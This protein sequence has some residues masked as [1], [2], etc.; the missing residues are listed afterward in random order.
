MNRYIEPI[1]GVS[2]AECVF[3]SEVD[4]CLQ[5]VAF[6]SRCQ[7]R[8]AVWQFADRDTGVRVNF[9]PSKPRPVRPVR[10]PFKPAALAAISK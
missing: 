2:C 5:V 9:T 7:T 3:H 1:H 8:P 6:D 4:V 10:P